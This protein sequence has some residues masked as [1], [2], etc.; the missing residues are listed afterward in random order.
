MKKALFVFAIM[1]LLSVNCYAKGQSDK[2]KAEEAVAEEAVAQGTG[3]RDW[4]AMEQNAW[5]EDGIIYAK[6]SAK[7]RALNMALQAAESRARTNLSAALASGE[8]SGY[9]PLPADAADVSTFDVNGVKGSFGDL[10]REA[11]F[12]ADDGTLFVLLTCRGAALE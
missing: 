8:I 12:E 11:V 7:M 6:G 3:A 4:M 9:A 1:V 5:V 2:S 10:E